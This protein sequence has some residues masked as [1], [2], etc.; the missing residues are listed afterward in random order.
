MLVD[1]A[2]AASDW[3]RRMA[4]DGGTVAF[5][6]ASGGVGCCRVGQGP[7]R[8]DVVK[9]HPRAV[10][11][12][13]LSKLHGAYDGGGVTAIDMAGRVVVSG[14]RGGQVQVHQAIPNGDSLTLE[15][16]TTLDVSV[17]STV[18]SVAV[19]DDGKTLVACALDG[20]IQGFACVD[21]EWKATWSSKNDAAALTVIL[22][23]ERDAC[24]VGFSDGEVYALDVNSGE[25][26]C[27]PFTTARAR[28][29]SLLVSDGHLF[30]GGADGSVVRRKL[31][32]DTFAIH[33]SQLIL[34]TKA[35][36]LLPPHGDAVV[37][38]CAPPCGGIVCTASRD[39]SIRVWDSAAREPRALYG[40][41]WFRPLQ[42]H[43]IGARLCASAD[44]LISDGSD[45]AIIQHTFDRDAE[46]RAPWT[47]RSAPRVT[48]IPLCP[49]RG[50]LIGDETMRRAENARLNVSFSAVARRSSC[51]RGSSTVADP[52]FPTCVT[53]RPPRPRPSYA[54]ASSVAA[55]RRRRH[56]DTTAR[57]RA[58]A[59]TVQ[60]RF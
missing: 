21:E 59:A 12:Q 42:V 37:A 3:V 33:P 41:R 22:D 19:A 8:A 57:D 10:E 46:A 2:V 60:R 53:A 52:E 13:D 24:V 5:G 26:L 48:R 51:A 27:E 30:V 4:F 38:M 28:C 23:E 43:T 44:T 55:R 50:R 20:S 25:E 16:V 29:R 18:S 32:V 40:F 47:R 58:R 11:G 45:N 17:G 49:R 7:S 14:G 39:G 6:T 54:V 56:D 36:R 1:S 34:E 9:A 31:C 35:D 15:A